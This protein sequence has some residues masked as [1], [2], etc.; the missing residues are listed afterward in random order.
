MIMFSYGLILWLMFMLYA[1][2]TSTDLPKDAFR[3]LM[4]L[5][6]MAQKKNAL[7]YVLI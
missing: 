6:E 3:W 1:F 7:K 4:K 5:D 2:V